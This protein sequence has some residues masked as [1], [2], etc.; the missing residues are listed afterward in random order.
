MARGRGQAEVILSLSVWLLK[1][2]PHIAGQYQTAC[3][4]SALPP[5]WTDP[6]SKQPVRLTLPTSVFNATVTETVALQER[7]DHLSDAKHI[8]QCSFHP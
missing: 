8:V 1:Y 7:P 5:C 2:R 4:Q 3:N 6:T